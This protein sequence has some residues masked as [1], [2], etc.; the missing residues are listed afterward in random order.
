[1]RNR[2]AIVFILLAAAFFRLYRITEFTEFLG[3]QGSAGMVIY[4][5]LQ[6]K[7]VPLAG[8]VISTGQRPGPF[9]YYLSALPLVLFRFNPIAPAVFMALIGM[10]TVYLL[11]LLASKLFTPAVA[12]GIAFLYALSPPIVVQDRTWWNPTTIPFLV[13]LLLIAMHK[14]ASEKKYEYFLL[15]GITTG[16]AVQ[17]HY[18]ALFH[19]IS[20]FIFTVFM[21]VTSLRTD[22][23]R[24]IGLWSLVGVLGFIFV[25]SPFLYYESARS[26]KDLKDLILL[27][28]YPDPA[29]LPGVTVPVWQMWSD[30]IVRVFVRIAALPTVIVGIL[31]AASLVH[32]LLN[33]KKW[34]MLISLWFLFGIAFVGLYKG[35]LFD[36]YLY[37]LLPFPFLLFG[38]MLVSFE[39][40]IP[41]VFL[42]G[43]IV[44]LTVFDLAALVRSG[45]VFNDIQRTQ[46]ATGE[47]I[48]QA[49]D[50]RFAFALISSRSFSDLHYR[51]YFLMQ[52]E[53]PEALAD[54]VY[55]TLF[56]VCETEICPTPYVLAQQN[57][58][59][60][61]CY[62]YYCEWNYPNL[63]M[64]QWRFIRSVEG[65][66]TIV[67]TFSRGTSERDVTP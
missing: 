57:A 60:V 32:A 44:C 11:Y 35:T 20:G 66:G 39:K 53:E 51:Y 4:Q 22:R 52:Q 41:R 6:E 15:V 55:D 63:D 19:V 18:T 49:A 5:S 62:D 50:H 28:L 14:V 42:Y 9:F 24:R 38:G 31:A 1:M 25:L 8:P 59:S 43:F 30:V 54:G 23:I 29:R 45:K 10:C 33:R 21:I 67:Y 13:L 3:D 65:N 27:V 36:H 64:T 16:L 61:V 47:I 2:Y 26:Y 37:F 46:M 56:L 7:T 40:R 58:V 34:L 12:A 48:R 17:L